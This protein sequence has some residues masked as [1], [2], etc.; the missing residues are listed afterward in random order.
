MPASKVRKKAKTKV[1]ADRRRLREQDES[2]A[3]SCC[4]R[5][6]QEVGAGALRLM[7]SVAK[8][9]PDQR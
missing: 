7:S 9:T 5:D 4:S 6:T 3:D 2:C 8:G 1:A